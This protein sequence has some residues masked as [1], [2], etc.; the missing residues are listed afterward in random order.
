MSLVVHQMNQNKQVKEGEEMTNEKLLMDKIKKSGKKMVY[1]AEKCNLSYAGFR[2]CI[3]NKAEF[4]VS[5]VD[6]LCSE[7]NITDLK[8]KEQIFY[9]KG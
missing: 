6:V 9:F 2:N 8:E 5:Q 1:L 4:R 3:K 7:L